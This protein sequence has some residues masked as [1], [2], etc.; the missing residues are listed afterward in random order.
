M[1]LAFLSARL[2]SWVLFAL[3]LPLVGRVL[4]TVGVRVGPRAPR[5]GQALQRTGALARTPLAGR[6]RRWRR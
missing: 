6:R 4:Q 1:I 2:R 5:V 3:V